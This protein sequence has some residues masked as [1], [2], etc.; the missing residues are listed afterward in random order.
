MVN[1][2]GFAQLELQ[3]LSREHQKRITLHSKAWEISLKNFQHD[4]NLKRLQILNHF[5]EWDPFNNRIL[6]LTVFGW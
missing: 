4:S 6:H 2:Q 5:A 1:R 3:N